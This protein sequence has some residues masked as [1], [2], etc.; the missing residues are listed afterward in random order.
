MLWA[1]GGCLLRLADAATPPIRN[2][3][4]AAPAICRS[5]C[6]APCTPPPLY[7]HSSPDRRH[8]SQRCLRAAMTAPAK[9]MAG[10]RSRGKVRGHRYIA[11][12]PFPAV[13]SKRNSPS[14]P[15]ARTLSK[16]NGPSSLAFT[17]GDDARTR[18]LGLCI[19]R[20]RTVA[21]FL[22]VAWGLRSAQ[23]GGRRRHGHG[24]HGRDRLIASLLSSV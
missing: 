24:R 7:M 1:L 2:G 19:F 10:P 9:A 6:S 13:W 23:R 22:N 8:K 3:T 11:C 15:S 16:G 4:D 5:R 21:A 17:S 12:V 14:P 18:G 20:R